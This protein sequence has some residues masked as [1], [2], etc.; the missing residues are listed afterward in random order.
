[1]ARQAVASPDV[2]LDAPDVMVNNGAVSFSI[3]APKLF[4]NTSHAPCPPGLA[5][6]ETPPA[7]EQADAAAPPTTGEDQ[8]VKPPPS[9]QA[10]EAAPPPATAE[11]QSVNVPSA[12][13][14]PLV[15]DAETVNR[16]AVQGSEIRKLFTVDETCAEYEIRSNIVADNNYVYWVNNSGLVR[17]SVN[18]NPGDPTQLL[19][20]Q[21]GGHT[22]L[23][24]DDTYII[25]LKVEGSNPSYTSR[26]WRV[27][28]VTGAATLL[29]TRNAYA[30]RI[31]SSSA[32]DLATG[33]TRYYVYWMEGSNLLRYEPATSSLTTIA[34]GVTAYYAEGGRISC[35]G[36]FCFITDLV[37]IAQNTQV[38]TYNNATNT[39]NA[40]FYTS[41]G[42]N[43]VFG[44]VTDNS[45]V[46]MLE[47]YYLPCSPLPCVGGTYTH[48]VTRAARNGSSPAT[49]Y[50][51]SSGPYSLNGPIQRIA[52]AGDYV[53]WLEIGGA[54]KRLPKNAS[55]LPLTNMRITGIMITQGIQRPDNSVILI[56]GRRTFVRVFV[57]SDGPAVPGVTAR[58]ERLDNSNNVIATVLPVNDVG[59][60][61][62]VRPNPVRENLNDSFLFELPWSWVTT[63]LRL[64]AAEPVQ[65]AAGVELHR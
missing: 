36:S 5:L 9:E 60:N 52:A 6:A 11:G 58:L 41:P 1:M 38:R 20:N 43:R 47:E 59:T 53:F 37:F 28:K 14:A 33:Q 56:A 39:L 4:W 17:L 46:L 54:I 15:P 2:P 24:I 45:Y 21:V 42:G 30:G 44:I 51:S 61:L 48:Y 34:T 50:S 19:N 32:L 62:T 55:A 10:H 49:L 29:Q 23:A 22:E 7:P 35:S 18:A 65:G 26:I 8:A 57:Q 63:G 25:V 3:A 27:N 31:S 64:R 13:D 16:I 40:P 12:P